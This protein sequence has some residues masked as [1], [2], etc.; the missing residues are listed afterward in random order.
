MYVFPEGE[1][2]IYTQHRFWEE[3]HVGFLLPSV[4]AIIV[5]RHPLKAS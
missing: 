2:C 1:R 3:R 5:N 4:L